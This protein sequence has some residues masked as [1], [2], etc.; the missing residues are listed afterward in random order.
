MPEKSRTATT[1]KFCNKYIPKPTERTRDKSKIN[2]KFTRFHF[3]IP[4]QQDESP[5]P[6]EGPTIKKQQK[7]PS[8]LEV[9]TKQMEKQQQTLNPQAPPTRKQLREEQTEIP[10][11]QH[12][13][14][15]K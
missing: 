12:Q 13:P 3:R 2:P 6:K 8:N 10:L 15:R 1:T 5:K 11:Q 14:Y 4:Q 7:E 9:I